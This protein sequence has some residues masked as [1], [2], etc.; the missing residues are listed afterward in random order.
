MNQQSIVLTILHLSH[1]LSVSQNSKLKVINFTGE[2]NANIKSAES[3]ILLISPAA[4][5]RGHLA[6]RAGGRG[7]WKGVVA[8]ELPVGTLR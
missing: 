7:A 3:T 1:L 6:A 8:G 5:E 2:R 4:L